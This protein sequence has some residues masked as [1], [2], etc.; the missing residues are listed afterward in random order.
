[1]ERGE[2]GERRRGGRETPGENGGEGE[3]ERLFELAFQLHPTAGLPGTN[4]CGC[5]MCV[6]VCV[7][8]VGRRSWWRSLA[9]P[10]TSTTSTLVSAPPPS[11]ISMIEC[12]PPS[13]VCY[14][15]GSVSMHSF[16]KP[17]THLSLS[18][19]PQSRHRLW[20]LLAARL[21]SLPTSEELEVVALSHSRLFYL[22]RGRKAASH[23]RWFPHQ[24]PPVP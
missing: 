16:S 24:P 17:T 12:P 4:E 7:V 11:L 3:R 21:A 22:L 9:L 14:L 23:F 18:L 8:R 20:A 6:C 19:S 13:L 5:C 1:M 2:T 15:P 10:T